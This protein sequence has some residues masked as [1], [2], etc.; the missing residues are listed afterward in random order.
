VRIPASLC[1]VYGHKATLGIIPKPGLGTP[2]DLAVKGPLARAPEDLA[3]L[4]DVLGA[5]GLQSLTPTAPGLVLQLPRPAK[6]ALA[7][8]TVRAVPGRLSAIISVFVCKSVLY[9]TFVCQGTQDAYITAK[10]GGFRPGQ[11][12]VWADDPIC[13]VDRETKAATAAVV[14]G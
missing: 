5:A 13:P 3:L 8:Y 6:K 7:E 14:V 9:G 1:G 2:Q 12:A 11:F 10:N 4:M